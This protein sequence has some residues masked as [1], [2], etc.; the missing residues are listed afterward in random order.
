MRASLARDQSFWTSSPLTVP[1]QASGS[2]PLRALA[3]K[4]FRAHDIRLMTRVPNSIARGDLS[5]FWRSRKPDPMQRGQSHVHSENRES[6]LDER[7]PHESVR[8]GLLPAR[9]GRTGSQ[10]RH[11]RRSLSVSP[12]RP[13]P[14]R[15]SK[16]VTECYGPAP[17]TDPKMPVIIDIFLAIIRAHRRPVLRRSPDIDRES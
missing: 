8:P 14:G 10:L 15:A 11:V 3:S 9:N 7:A 13:D 17:T 16:N 6:D 2:R 5:G 4:M 12:F 1:P